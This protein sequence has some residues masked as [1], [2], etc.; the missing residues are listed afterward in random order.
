LGV[1]S[2]VLLASDLDGTLYNVDKELS[3]ENEQA[4][5]SFMAQG[6]RFAVATGRSLQGYACVREGI[7][8]NAPAVL[9]NGALVFDY[10]TQ[11]PLRVVTLSKG[12]LQLCQA[13]R[14][15]FPDI[16]LEAHLL[17]GVWALG[18]NK[19]SLLHQQIVKTSVT[20]AQSPA[21]VPDGWL[22]ALFIAPHEEL[23]AL[24]NWMLPHCRGK[25]D[26]VFSHP[27][28]LEMQDARADKGEGVSWLAWHLDIQHKHVYCAG[29]YQNDLSMLRRFHSFA[30]SSSLP[31]IRAAASQVGPACGEHFIAWVIAQL[32]SQYTRTP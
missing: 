10:E 3:H 25:Y 11:T 23:L 31:E 28:L 14:S 24:R 1:F 4:L 18:E 13:A 21:D 7:P 5:R 2:G 22:K 30:P 26:L 16:V 27:L 19:Y 32:A 12:F 15:S 8:S 17:D 20:P 9:S 29:D 6:G